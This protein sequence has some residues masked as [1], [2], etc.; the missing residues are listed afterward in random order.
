MEEMHSRVEMVNAVT[1]EHRHRINKVEQWCWYGL[2][3][4]LFLNIGL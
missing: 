4:F 1:A 3:L 2:C